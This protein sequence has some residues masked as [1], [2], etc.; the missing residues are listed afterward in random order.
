VQTEL[1][2]VNSV[3]TGVLPPKAWSEKWVTPNPAA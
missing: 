1:K 2:V 3:S